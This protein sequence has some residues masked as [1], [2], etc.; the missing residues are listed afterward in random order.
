MDCL[1]KGEESALAFQQVSGRG[2]IYSHALIHGTR[3]AEFEDILPYTVILVEL[4]EQKGLIVN[5]NMPDT[6]SEKVH[7]D[8]PVEVYFID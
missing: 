1:A 8:V 4:E 7:S 5:A 6:R 2:R 3:L